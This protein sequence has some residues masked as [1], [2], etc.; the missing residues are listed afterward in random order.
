MSSKVTYRQQFTRCGKQRCRKCRE[1]SGH[2]PY[3]YAYWSEKG[4]TVSKYIGIHLPTDIDTGQHPYEEDTPA[5][6]TPPPA[7]VPASPNPTLRVYLLGQFRIERQVDGEWRSLDSRTWHRR[8]ARALLGC[9]LSSGGRRLGREQVMELLWPDLDI[10]LAANR[11]NGA[12]HE[13]RHILEP[14][15]ARPAASRLLRLERDIL[16]LAD[17]TQIW[18]DA[19]A[20]ENLL[21]AADATSDI[22]QMERLLEE[23]AALYRGNYLLEELYSEWA[24]PRRD[25]L[26]RAWVGLL[27][28]LAEVRVAQE[29]Y[30]SAIE[31]LDRLRTADP[32]NETVLQRLMILL[33]QRDRRGEALQIYRQHVAMLERDYEGE[34]LPET[35]ALY[36]MLCKGHVP[37]LPTDTSRLVQHKEQEPEPPV[38]QSGP[39][40]P[41]SQPQLLFT[42]PTFQRGRHNQSPLIGRDW[43]LETLRHIMLALEGTPPEVETSGDRDTHSGPSRHSQSPS[44]SLRSAYTHFLLLK[45][46]AGI[47][48]TRLA[49][50]LSLE[51]YSRGWTVVWSRSYEQ[52][53]TIPYHPWTNLLRTLL[54]NTAT[55]VELL[56]AAQAEH[57]AGQTAS[58]LKLERLGALLPELAQYTLSHNGRAASPVPHEQERLLLWEA[59]Q[60]LLGMLSTYHPLLLVL[61][62]LHWADESSIELLTYLIHHLRDQRVLLVGTCRDGE[63]APQHKLR[64]LTADL[65][66][67][68]AIAVISVLP[69]TSSQIGTLVAHLPREIVQSIQTQASGNPFFAEELARFREIIGQEEDT[70]TTKQRTGRV[71]Y[72]QSRASSSAPASALT[73]TQRPLPEAIAAVLER[74][75]NRLSRDCQN[76]LSKAAVLGGSFELSQLLPM[77]TEYD[78]DTVLDLLE[79]A[80][81]AGLL[82]EEGT[83]AHILYHFWHPLIISHLYG[84]LSAARRAQLH[85]KAAEAI[86]AA[87]PTRPDKA[88]TIVYHL[89][90]GG[91]DP[92]TIAYYAELAGNQAYVLAAYSEAQQYYLQATSALLNN[93]A[94]PVDS[95]DLQAHVQM[96]I[97]QPLSSLPLAE[98]LRV[99]RLLEQVAEC[100]NVLGNYAQTRQIIESIL[101][102]RSSARF[103]HQ[104][105]P[106]SMTSE[107]A[108]RQEAQIQALLWREISQTWS[109]TGE[110]ERSLACYERGKEVMIRAGVASGVAWAGLFLQYGAILR[111]HGN[112][113]EARRY[114]QDALQILEQSVQQTST[115]FYET[116]NEP[117]NAGVGRS[118]S[119]LLSLT[120]L[121]TRTERALRGDPLEI[122]YAHER[123][124]IVAAS[125]G[126]L[127]DALV[128]MQTSLSIYERSELISDMARVCGNLG[129]V[130]ITK[131]EHAAASMYMHRC[132]DLGE[133]AGNLPNVTFVMQNLGDAAL[134]AGSLDEAQEWLQ[135]SSS[136]A[137]RLHDRESISWCCATRSAA[138]KEQG[139]LHE[140]A[141]SILQAI[142]SGRAIKNTR[143]IRFALL[144]LA[145]LRIAQAITVHTLPTSTRH[146][147][148]SATQRRRLLLRA[149]AILQRLIGSAGIELENIIDGKY[150]LAKVYFLLGT[151]E[152]ALTLALQTLKEAQDCETTRSQARVLRLLGLIFAARHDYQQANTYFEQALQVGRTHEYRLD[153]ARTLHSYGTVL[154][155]RRPSD[156]P[157]SADQ[158]QLDGNYQRGLDYLH[159]A[160]AIVAACHAAIDVDFIEYDFAQFTAPPV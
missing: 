26:Q 22:K 52:E 97:S 147:R 109:L 156:H 150:L 31:T 151:H 55:L 159:E 141:A 49:E 110:Y 137:E 66:R 12:V 154:M 45:G 20:F 27:L 132:L 112:Y 57:D 65:Q 15:I 34:P 5:P 9:L 30:V 56:R 82:T 32:T 42:R 113:Y 105:Y 155:Q 148:D 41:I 63:L 58:P 11:L 87:Y 23:A 75:L 71:A 107:E 133:R 64:T 116:V 61:D 69:L 68:Q 83:G 28:K 138:Q 91:G 102:L 76:L 39:P 50:E 157:F 88:A 104:V 108:H 80:L 14:D 100:S 4:R 62:D 140:A 8:R 54:P 149:Q 81:H 46:E 119:P 130:Y 90:R 21:K 94:H 36:D 122:G 16:E 7:P 78:E 44:T 60:G 24:T 85:R 143:S 25:A 160:R 1:G 136:L 126:Q 40:Q 114:L 106:P 101:E 128:H 43:E 38:V 103:L 142:Q 123:L 89:T 144:M 115:P 158:E 17:S 18:V 6:T 53:G 124:G 93:E 37:T 118:N 72:A 35:V 134:R 127:S 29:A 129:A 153:Y 19:E 77:A 79:E 95:G 96:L 10:D 3:W 33:T 99:C 70:A 73:R 135:K 74:R 117:L 139:D 47:G 146:G 2:G 125:L 152:A 86:R 84:R 59:T 121:P 111:L 51:A 145:D 120:H 13:L 98:P 131:G 48:K 67:E 92:T